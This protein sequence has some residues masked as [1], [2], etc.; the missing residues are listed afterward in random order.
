[1][2][3]ILVTDFLII[4]MIFLRVSAMFFSAPLFS[5][6]SIPM[7]ARLFLA[8][9]VSYITFNSVQVNSFITTDISI[10]TL[11]LSAIKEMIIG[12]IF[13]FTMQFIFYAV[14]FAG[15]VIGFEI[16]LSMAS[17]IDPMQE[18]TSNVIGEVLSIA[19]FLV[20]ILINGHHYLIQGIVYSFTFLPIGK[21]VVNEA[22]LELLLK[23]SASIFIIAIK[24]SAPAIV[25]LFLLNVVG[26]I[27]A[28]AIPQMQVFFVLYPLK[29][30]LGIFLLAAISPALIYFIK[31]ILESYENNLY[32]LLKAMGASTTGNC[33]TLA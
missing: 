15:H 1:M 26:A 22:V 7:I 33:H 21:F 27:V 6:N 11:F 24:I 32:E 8:L 28:R 14:S 23:Y 4:L 16:G 9:V 19:T 10:I 20:F 29:L 2:T 18:T 13:G 3:E 5:N 12:L 17:V 25:T 30:G 31:N